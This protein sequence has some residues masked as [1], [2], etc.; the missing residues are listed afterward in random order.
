MKK[1]KKIGEAFLEIKKENS[2][3]YI[4]ILRMIFLKKISTRRREKKLF[5]ILDKLVNIIKIEHVQC[6]IQ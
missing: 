1:K 6:T 3:S 2:N 4:V 5:G